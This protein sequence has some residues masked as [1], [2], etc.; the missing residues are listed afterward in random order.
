MITM[1]GQNT[2]LKQATLMKIHV[3]QEKCNGCGLCANQYPDLF[4]MVNDEAP[5]AVAVGGLV[6]TFLI[7]SAERM[8][9]LCPEESVIIE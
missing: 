5:K 4:V 7:V 3:D 8:E 9:E 2:G 6:P 1:A